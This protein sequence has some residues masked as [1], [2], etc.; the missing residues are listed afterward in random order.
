MSNILQ[1]EAEIKA[2]LESELG[3]TSLKRMNR[4]SMYSMF[5]FSILRK[6][7]SRNKSKSGQK[8]SRK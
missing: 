7:K 5:S 2:K 8:C 1:L 6:V 3:H 4:C